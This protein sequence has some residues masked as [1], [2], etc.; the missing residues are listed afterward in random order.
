M[1]GAGGKPPHRGEEG[2]SNW[3]RATPT[4][5]C[6]CYPFSVEMAIRR[7]RF[8]PFDRKVTDRITQCC[9]K[10][11]SSHLNVVKP[12][13]EQSA[14]RRERGLRHGRSR[15]LNSDGARRNNTMMATNQKVGGLHREL[16]WIRNFVV[17]YRDVRCFIVV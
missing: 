4:V 9:T 7:R 16:R 3:I 5:W 13:D 1:D 8:R 2:G 6:D 15:V 14:G 12:H 17:I 10:K 11:D